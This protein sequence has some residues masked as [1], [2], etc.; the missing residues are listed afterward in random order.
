MTAANDN[1][2]PRPRI[3]PLIG[4]VGEDGKVTKLKVVRLLKDPWKR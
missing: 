2:L 4:T 1:P 3:I